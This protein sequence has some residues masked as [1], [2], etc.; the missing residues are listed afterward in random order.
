[1]QRKLF[2]GSPTDLPQ[3][4]DTVTRQSS[5]ILV[6]AYQN[7]NAFAIRCLK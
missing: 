7:F 2:K 6:P 5:A 4:F 1:M 3:K